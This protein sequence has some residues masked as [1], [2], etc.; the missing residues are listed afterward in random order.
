MDLLSW[1]SHRLRMRVRCT[2]AADSMAMCEATKAALTYHAH[3]AE[4]RNS[5]FD[6]R[7]VARR[8]SKIPL[9]VLTDC[10]SLY[11]HLQKQASSPSDDK[12]ALL[13]VQSLRDLRGTTGLRV[14]W[15][16]SAQMVADALT[17]DAESSHLDHVLQTG[18]TSRRIQTSLGSLPKNVRRQRRD[19]PNTASKTDQTQKASK[20]CQEYT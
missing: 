19:E 3:T 5:H 15:V 11:D 2:C 18:C 16:A 14:R 9:T 1:G 7:K 20:K 13:Y 17:R 12:R 6:L 10:E 8:G 4:L